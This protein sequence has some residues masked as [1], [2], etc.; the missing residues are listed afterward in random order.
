MPKNAEEA[1][2]LDRINGN[3]YWEKSIKKEMAKVRV[4][5]KPHEDHTPD[6]VRRGKAPEMT[7][8]QEITCHLIFDVKMDFTRKARFVANGSTTDAPASVTYSSVVSR[9]SLASDSRS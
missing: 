6:E 4:A 7:G 2:Q 5:Y 3:D 8:Y 9:D 1:L